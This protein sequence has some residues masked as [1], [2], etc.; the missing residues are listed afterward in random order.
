MTMI[1]RTDSDAGFTEAEARALQGKAVGFSGG[2]SDAEGEVK[3]MMQ[4]HGSDAWKVGVRW[5]PSG[6]VDWYE[7]GSFERQLEIAEEGG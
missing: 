5:E 2:Q 6:D 1:D 3:Y 7:K 4:M